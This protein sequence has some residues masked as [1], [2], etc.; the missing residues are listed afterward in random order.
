MPTLFN[1]NPSVVRHP[2][3]PSHEIL[4]SILGEN[5]EQKVTVRGAVLP[6][7]MVGLIHEPR[8]GLVRP[9]VVRLVREP[10]TGIMR[11]DIVGLLQEITN[12]IVSY[13]GHRTF[14]IGTAPQ[15]HSYL[16]PDDKN[17]VLTKEKSTSSDAMEVHS[18]TNLQTVE[19][20][21]A[22]EGQ[23]EAVYDTT[24]TTFW[25]SF[26]E[27]KGRKRESNAF[28]VSIAALT[29]RL[30]DETQVHSS[31][32]YLVCKLNKNL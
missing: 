7:D 16:Q 27:G 26:N 31:G 19:L 8:T 3:P 18:D 17:G 1:C 30:E 13:N 25:Q 6:D 12:D 24:D 15:D 29:T 2:S 10:E 32:F 22:S 9:G 21:E 20:A 23:R 4:L 28:S 14:V 11:P 5:S